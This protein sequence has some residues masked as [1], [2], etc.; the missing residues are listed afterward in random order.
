MTMGRGWVQLIR[1]DIDGAR[2]SLE[3]AVAAAGL[4][5]STRIT[6]W[7]LAWLARVQ[8]ASGDWDRALA[9]VE[10]GRELADGAES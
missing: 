4:G 2:S 3:S 10:A 5:G 7:S 6:L 8:F 9:S 1:D